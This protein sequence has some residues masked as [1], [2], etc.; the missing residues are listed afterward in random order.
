MKY[1]YTMWTIAIP[2]GGHCTFLFKPTRRECIDAFN[3]WHPD[4]K[5]N[6]ASRKGWKCVKIL[7]HPAQ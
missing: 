1:P 2:E 6:Q 4:M 7:C 3:K 5:W